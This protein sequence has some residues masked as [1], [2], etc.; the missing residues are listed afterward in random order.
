MNFIDS[1]SH[2]QNFNNKIELVLNTASEIGCNTHAINTVSPEDWNK[3]LVLSNTSKYCIVPFLGI[4]PWCVT[5]N[6]SIQSFTQNLEGILKIARCGVGE[7]GL[8]RVR[9]TSSLAVQEKFFI[10]Q[11]ELALKYRKPVS[12]HSVKAH[13]EIIKIIKNLKI[14]PVFMVHSFTGSIQMASDILN[15]GGFI[16]L[17]FSA[18]KNG[19]S[20]LRKLLE[21]IPLDRLLLETDSPDMKLPSIHIFSE[22][23]INLDYNNILLNSPAN[24]HYL[25]EIISRIKGI[26]QNSLVDNITM[27]FE[28]FIEDI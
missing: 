17:S 20:K 12:I 2:L 14:L 21:Y 15:L 25:Y 3:V 22:F 16:S 1:H 24:I 27:N 10:S 18:L 13:N 6:L 9:V 8:D 23:G 26:D 7:V 11:L 5:E 28:K 19:E 4:H